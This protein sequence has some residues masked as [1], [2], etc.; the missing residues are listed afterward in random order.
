MMKK[1]STVKN[2]LF[3]SLGILL[4]ASGSALAQGR[5]RPMI[6][7]AIPLPQIGR[8]PAMPSIG[9]VVGPAETANTQEDKMSV[10]WNE[11]EFVVTAMLTEVQQGPTGL[12]HPPVYSNRLTFVVERVLRGTFVKNETVLASHS[13]RQ[14]QEPKFP[15]GE[16]CLVAISEVRGSF[17]VDAIVKATE[18]NV[19]EAVTACLLPIGW[20]LNGENAVSPWDAAWPEASELGQDAELQCETTGRPALLAGPGV[21]LDLEPVPPAEEIRWTNPDGDGEYKLTVT[22][23]TDEPLTIPAL[24]CDGDEILWE[25]S[26]VVL[27]QEKT[28]VCPGYDAVPA[29]VSSVELAPGESVSMVVNALR[30]EGPEWPRGGYRIEFRF[31]LGELSQTHSFYYMSRHHDGLR[32]R[33]LEQNK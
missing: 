7:P 3:V 19:T 9:P 14:L 31:C 2:W 26:L 25:E 17:R 28:Y 21:Q 32:E 33:A 16:L 12:S 18:E 15:E 13:A 30:L 6:R 11:S 24:L 27:C 20:K 10:A 8:G 5:P 4:V 1:T 22:N 23:T 29:S